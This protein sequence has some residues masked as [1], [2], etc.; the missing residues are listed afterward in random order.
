[1]KKLLLLLMVALTGLAPA[2]MVQAAEL[3]PSDSGESVRAAS[4]AKHLCWAYFAKRYQLMGAEF[5]CDVKLDAPEAIQGWSGRWRMHGF[6]TVRNYRNNADWIAREKAIRSD[7]QLSAKEK[8]RQID[9]ERLIKSELIEFE[10][11]VSNLDSKPEI[12]VTLR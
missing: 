8:R 6:A 12:D 3:T 1:M 5:E 7:T 2:L 11:V 10:A 9:R 4:V